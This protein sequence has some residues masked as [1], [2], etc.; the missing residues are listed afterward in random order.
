MVNNKMESC[1]PKYYNGSLHSRNKE[2]LGD[3]S[4]YSIIIDDG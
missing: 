4:A 2:L 3:L 1:T